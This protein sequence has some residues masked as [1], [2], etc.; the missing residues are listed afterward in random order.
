[1]PEDDGDTSDDGARSQAVIE[2][3]MN[4]IPANEQTT[5]DIDDLLNVYRMEVKAGALNSESGFT[6]EHFENDTER[7]QRNIYGYDERLAVG[8][9]RHYLPYCVVGY[10]ASGCTATLIGPYHALTAAHCVYNKDT[11]KWKPFSE[12]NLY[13]KMDCNARGVLMYARRAWSVVG[14]TQQHKYEYD[15]ALIIYDSSYHSPCY[16]S[17]GYF[18]PW[19]HVGFDLTGYPVDKCNLKGCSY[20]SMW[21]GSCHYSETVNAGL[22][23]RYRCD[24]TNGNSGSALYGEWKD[25]NYVHKYVYGVNAQQSVAKTGKNSWNWGPRITRDRFYQI[26]GWMQ[27]SGYNPLQ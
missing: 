2:L 22:R 4:E 11:K 25:S 16:L 12:L 27:D 18:N 10:L 1:M 14:Y 6:Q 26:I 15:Y 5:G 17:F 9:R 20:C 19:S 13:R 8:Y 23:L 3:D 21:F 24:M 7:V